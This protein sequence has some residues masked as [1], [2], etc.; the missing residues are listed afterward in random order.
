MAS[1]TG[2]CLR[3]I[4]LG[5]DTPL[6]ILETC[7]PGDHDL[8]R[9]R[10]EA[11][12]GSLDHLVVR[13][14]HAYCRRLLA[15]HPLEAGIH[16]G[17]EIDADGAWRTEI[18]REVVESALR[19]GYG[20]PGSPVLLE[21][22]ARGY[23]PQ[24]LA[25]ALGVLVEKGVPPDALG[26]DPF[27]GEAVGRA[28]KALESALRALTGAMAGRQAEVKGRKDVLLRVMEASERTP[29]LLRASPGAGAENVA[30]FVAK[31]GETWDASAMK[32]LGEWS[33]G[34]FNKNEEKAFGDAAVN[35]TA[36]A[37]DLHAALSR[38]TPLD[39]ILLDLARRA[40]APLL[41]EIA[42]RLRRRGAISYEGL[43]QE[44]HDLLG[45][46][47]GVLA[48]IR[49]GID[50]LLV[51]EF[52]DTDALQCE[53]IRNIGLDMHPEAQPGLFVVGDP[54]QSIYGWRRADM[55]AYESFLAALEDAGGVK[56]TLSV[57][58]RSVPAVLDE[59]DR[60]M[61]PVM[62]REEGVQPGFEPLAPVEHNASDRG[63]I[64][65]GCAPVEH[66]V[67]QSWNQETGAPSEKTNAGP[68]ARLE[69]RTL[70]RDIRRLHDD[71]GVEWPSFGVLFRARGD[72]EIYL[73]AFR[74][75]GVP[76]SV[77]GDR[78][79]YKRREIVE[80]AALVRCVLDPND[81]LA[82]L[83]LLRSVLVGAPDAAIV[84]LWRGELPELMTDLEGPDE[85]RLEKIA[86]LVTEVQRELPED[87][88]G[89]ARIA[90]WEHALLAAVQ[91]IALA[92]SSFRR[93]PADRFV[94][95]LRI[96]FLVEATESAR[97][98]GTY[99]AANL[100]RFFR[101]LLQAIEEGGGDA[102]AIA[103][104]LRQAVAEEEEAEEA[105]PKDTVQDAVQVM[106][107]HQAKGLDFDHVYV[108]QLH[109]SSRAG[110]Q[111]LDDAEVIDGRLEYKLLGA[112][113]P[114]YDAVEES[115]RRVARAEVVRTL[116]VALTR[117]KKRL[118]MAGSRRPG[119]KDPKEESHMGLLR[120]RLPD[121]NDVM[122]LMAE[123]GAEGSD[124]R[125]DGHGARWFFP[126]L[127]AAAHPGRGHAERDAEG[128]F[129]P[130]EIA[131]DT[132]TLRA[133]GA[134]ARARMSR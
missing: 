92:R 54:K 111:A 1:V 48:R 133:L 38:I 5:Q 27:D 68:A 58:F 122:A 65:G 8:R 105:R 62:R 37:T 132:G 112:A 108:M 57:N 130:E 7:L 102:P 110:K 125:A 134:E 16:P 99:R 34:K 85:R 18:T 95:K 39:P 50:Q 30:A 75:E 81:H 88:P 19:E 115:R 10:A 29:D 127:Q 26:V 31:L 119:G 2:A 49:E 69:A 28:L 90:G 91:E 96:R 42:R 44:A 11:L 20:E 46:H 56:K 15:A 70:A 109:R 23:G 93:D 14:I 89:L 114:G 64:E 98:L 41:A 107:I 12:L 74:D 24:H 100:D 22:A 47:P 84:P 13:T 94:E 120:D 9:A 123:L 73:R 52:Q 67:S 33:S 61:R 106:T 87:I 25:D 104:A 35:I 86:A 6:G 71:H 126:G 118:V 124:A 103:R 117:A 43:L 45:R 60:I 36:A 55:A 66:W 101:E 79:Y 83:T 3:E 40:L 53:I 59:V 82:L 97:S 131:A 113:T 121:G 4:A 63:F 116:Y 78:T 77:E 128:L 72:L 32:R 80:A 76:F 21:L 17:F 51:D 129:S